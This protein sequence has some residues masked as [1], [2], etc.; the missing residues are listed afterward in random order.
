MKTNEKISNLMKSI[1]PGVLFASSAIGVSHL[2]Q[3]TRAGAD[4]GFIMFWFILF[5]N[6]FKYPFFEYGPRYA[7]ATG[8]SLLQ[9][10]LKLGKWLLYIFY[11]IS[12]LSMFTIT[13]AVSFVTV[14]LMENLL[15]THLHLTVVT[16]ILY[17]ICIVILISGRYNFLD[18]I[19][20]IIGILLVVSTVA[21]F[22]IALL[23]GPVANT[24]T[25]VHKKV[26][27]PAGI[28]FIIALMG[29][30]PST[31]D[32]ST[33][34]SLWTLERIKQTKYHPKLKETL[35][36]FNAGYIISGTLAFAFLLLG[37]YIMYGTGIQFSNN[38]VTFASQVVNLYTSTLGSWSYAIIAI[39][40]FTAMFSTTI[41]V[42][43]GFARIME[44]ATS[45]IFIKKLRVNQHLHYSLWLILVG[46][47][48]YL[49]I[50]IYLT[51]LK[52]L[53]DMATTISFL[54]AP[55]FA[56]VNYILITSKHVPET[57]RPKR[58]LR[59]LSFLGIIYLVGFALLYL[60]Y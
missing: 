12:F 31:I 20:K 13:A 21:A 18:L 23:H 56:I 38:P 59:I 5:A 43:D 52:G 57:A 60:F 55:F 6:V 28:A 41:I 46:I 1:G 45:L 25:F 11:I 51:R 48:A 26:F 34:N 47:G 37:V 53:V 10:Y 9:G 3:S 4:Y 2:V 29:W 15:S 16:A 58:W 22:A 24:D 50:S 7:N 17:A 49:I 30:M 54:V 44:H 42:F 32:V 39:S 36:D 33:W 19:I 27:D 14:G 40:A 35:F 8:E